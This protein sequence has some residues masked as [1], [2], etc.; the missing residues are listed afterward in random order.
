MY[1]PNLATIRLHEYSCFNILMQID[2]FKTRRQHRKI[3]EVP[4]E[5]EM[6]G[7][8]HRHLK[9]AECELRR[10]L[11]CGA[12]SAPQLQWDMS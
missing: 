2:P 8:E 6:H 10:M 9:I 4:L 7:C 1:M 3:H 12:H 5:T 11:S